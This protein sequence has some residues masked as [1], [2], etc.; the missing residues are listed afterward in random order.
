MRNEPKAHAERIKV[1]Q[2]IT[3]EVDAIR[4]TLT[5]RQAEAVLHVVGVVEIGHEG[6][7]GRETCAVYD[8]LKAAGVR[9][10]NEQPFFPGWSSLR[11]KEDV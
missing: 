4:L 6:S 10:S 8:A 1:T 3:Q 9:S 5:P 11:F 7:M 2:Q